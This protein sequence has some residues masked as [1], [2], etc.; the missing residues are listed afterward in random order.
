ML[1]LAVTWVAKEGQERRAADLF[2][3]LESESR[4][5]AGCA[6]YVV[7]TRNDNP[8]EFFIYEQYHDQ[9]A[10]DAHRASAHF[11]RIA[12]GTLSECAERKD[13]A[14]FTPIS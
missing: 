14:L 5:E 8:R 12:R 10:L 3:E 4:N 1:V 2:R 9:A 7:H 13:G 11:Q 6:M